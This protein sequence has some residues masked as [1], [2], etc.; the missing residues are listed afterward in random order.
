MNGE[1]F[2]NAFAALRDLWLMGL[3]AEIIEIYG[4]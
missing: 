3:H 4:G 1:V 2:P